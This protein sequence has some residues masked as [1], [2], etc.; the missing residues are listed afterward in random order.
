MYERRMKREEETYDKKKNNPPLLRSKNDNKYNIDTAGSKRKSNFLN[1]FFSAA[2]LVLA[3]ISCSSSAVLDVV[4]DKLVLLESPCSASCLGSSEETAM[5]VTSN[6]YVDLFFSL[7]VY[8]ASCASAM[9]EKRRRRCAGPSNVD[10]D[11]ENNNSDSNAIQYSAASPQKKK[12]Q[13]GKAR[14]AVVGVSQPLTLCT[15]SPASP[16]RSTPRPSAP[17]NPAFHST[18]PKPHT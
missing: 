5:M 11:D 3:R 14:T 2:G 13:K 9:K 7:L 1:N 8:L 17:V 6:S 16:S 4:S 12:I 18:P 10:G 15:S